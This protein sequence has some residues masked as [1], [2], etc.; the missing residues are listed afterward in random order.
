MKFQS[1]NSK[2]VVTGSL[3]VLINSKMTSETF[4]TGE[5]SLLHTHIVITTF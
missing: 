3:P 5:N 4:S 1:E 2:A